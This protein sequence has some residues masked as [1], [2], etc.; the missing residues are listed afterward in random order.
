MVPDTS[1]GPI[2]HEIAATITVATPNATDAR[3]MRVISLCRGEANAFAPAPGDSCRVLCT[4]A[5]SGVSAC[6]G[7][8]GKRPRRPR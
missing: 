6:L 4:E 1:P 5:L 3:T 2:A 7:A 8:G